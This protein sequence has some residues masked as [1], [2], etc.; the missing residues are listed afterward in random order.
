[1]HK[2]NKIT[3]VML[4]H[5]SER[6][7]GAEVQ[8]NYLAQ[9]LVERGYV[10]SYICQ[11]I[12]SN[13]VNTT[14]IDNGVKIHWL[15]T[16]SKFI[17]L[18]NKTYLKTLQLIAPD[19]IIQRNSSP[20]LWASARFSK[21]TSAKLIWICTDNLA[22]FR[23]FLTKRYKTKNDKKK[24]GIIKYSVFYISALFSD[25]L[26]NLAMKQVDFA[27]SQN[28]FQKE[29]I[30]NNFSLDSF[31]MISG[32]PLSNNQKSIL[33][34][35]EN[36]TIL[37]CANLG[38]HKRPELF[39]ELASKM[40]KTDY[41]FVLVGGHADKNYLNELFQNVPHNLKVTGHLSFS[42][43]LS[44]FDE[45]SVLINTSIS[46]GFSNTYIQSWLRGIPTIVFG[47]DPDDVIVDNNLGF[48][49]DTIQNA[50]DKLSILLND[51]LLYSDIS[52]NAE[53]YAK[54]N[55]TIST[56]TDH[57]INTLSKNL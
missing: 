24:L 22:P 28:E 20:I 29:N 41:Q 48:N 26:R 51:K 46:E 43:A 30:K 45:A 36:K 3:F 56:M 35:Y 7:G 55:H 44:Y 18:N 47:A 32:H 15:K 42:E 38:S 4:W 6:G 13:K 2:E 5:I 39:I 52:Y 12:N 11:T 8:A 23:A 33:D 9:E 34:R 25:K 10:V 16:A 37:W 50:E 49:V 54:K 1:M 31:K 14:S 53:Q 21:K 17:W 27:F 57:F 40:I 19:I